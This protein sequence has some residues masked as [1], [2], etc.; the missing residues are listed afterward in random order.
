M[1]EALPLRTWVGFFAMSG[2]TFMA[3]LDTQIVASSL[4]EI[5]ARLGATIEEASWI[6]TAYMIAEAIMIP[7]SGWLSRSLSLRYLYSIACALFTLASLCCAS[8]WSIGSILVFR[9][10]QG[11]CSG[12]LTPLLYQGIYMMFPR[13]RQAEVTLYVVLIVS[14]A[15]IIGPTLGGWITQTYS[16]RWLFLLNLLPGA[17]VTGMVFS[18]VRGEGPKWDLL[19]Q[20]DF[21]GILLAALFLGCL[22]YVLGEGPDKDWF[23]SKLIVSM[24]IVAGVSAILF[25]WRELACRYPVVNLRTFRDRNFSTGCLFNFIMGVGL[26]G[27]GYLMTLF[28]SMVKGFNSLQIG[29]IM[30]VPGIAM[31][32]SLPLVRILRRYIDGRTCLG[33]GLFM[34]GL[35]LSIN[36]SLTSETGFE[37]LFWPQ[38]LRGVA[39]MFCLSAITELALGRLSIEAVPNASGLYS[40]M[41]SLGGGIGIAVIN[42]M[43]EQRTALHYWRLAE[44]L[45]PARFSD[46]LDQLQT[47][48]GGRMADLEQAGQGG[49]K[50]LA[51]LVRRESLVMAYN[52]MWFLVA[53]LFGIMF[54]LVSV[55]RKVERRQ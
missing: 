3:V 46:Y 40:L 43:V 13:K 39:I 2:G 8:S 29:R 48:F 22:E 23:D 44:T 35:A 45:N 47:P 36:S 49:V 16:W 52:D 12:I 24:A 27:T 55:V 26:F 50:V 21:L 31:L 4:P 17:L 37:Q 18:L 5:S 34:F 30:A 33:L 53:V 25:V 9:I 42:Y 54:L 51:K 6:Q 11:M 14:F 15:P 32:T 20:F 28:L 10:F 1:E 7:L 19:K 38:V 41:R